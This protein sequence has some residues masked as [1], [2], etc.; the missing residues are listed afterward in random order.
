MKINKFLKIVLF[1]AATS[2]LFTACASKAPNKNVKK[3]EKAK[4]KNIN[5]VLNDSKLFE[6]DARLKLYKNK[7]TQEKNRNDL[8]IRFGNLCSDK[9]GKLVYINHFINKSYVNSY[10]NNK[11]YICEVDNAPYFIAH[12]ASQNT[13]SYLSISVDENIKK[14]YL[15]KENDMKFE[16]SL[17]TTTGTTSGPKFESTPPSQENAE[18][19][20]KEREEIEKRQRARE[21]KTKLLFDKKDQTTMTFFDTW[22]QT[23]V[24]PLCST[25]CKSIN[26]KSTGF[27][28]LKEATDTKWQ[29]V[30]KIGETSETVDDTCTCTGSSVILKKLS[31]ENQASK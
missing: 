23:G 12:M 13:N 10:A 6:Y 19:G 20:K 14:E 9:K 29:I 26:K 25:K 15:A 7:F 18:D 17:E 21:Q 11:A 22:K 24:D 30:S 4:D 1:I 5:D 2:V 8:L 3:V 16:S 31:N 27:T 28:T